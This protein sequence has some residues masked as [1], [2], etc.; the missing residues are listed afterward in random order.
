MHFAHN[1]DLTSL[2]A[3]T[4]CIYYLPITRICSILEFHSLFTVSSWFL[5][6]TAVLHAHVNYHPIKCVH[7]QPLYL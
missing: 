3:D 5:Y 6:N 1:I 7:V 2:A 4:C